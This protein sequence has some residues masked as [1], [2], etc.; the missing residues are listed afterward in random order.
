MMSVIKTV[1][2]ILIVV[3]YWYMMK[4]KKGA[5]IYIKHNYVY[6]NNISN[7]LSDTSTNI[8]ILLNNYIFNVNK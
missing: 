1:K 3:L 4:L 7:E 8:T 6:N 5:I 2:A